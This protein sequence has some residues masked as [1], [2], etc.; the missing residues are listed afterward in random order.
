MR[1]IRF[2]GVGAVSKAW[3]PPGRGCGDHRLARKVAVGNDI[4]K[5]HTLIL[6]TLSRYHC[7][8]YRL[9]G[10]QRPV[11]SI[12]RHGEDGA[13]RCDTAQR[14]RSERYQRYSG[15]GGRS[16]R[17]WRLRGRAK[18]FATAPLMA[19][20][21]RCRQGDLNIMA[22]NLTVGPRVM[23]GI[24]PSRS[25]GFAFGTALPAPKQTMRRQPF[26]AA[27][28]LVSAFS[29]TEPRTRHP[30]KSRASDPTR[31]R[32]AGKDMPCSIDRPRSG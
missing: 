2:G 23:A 8:P 20:R 18:A 14:M 24:D 22:E 13:W 10:R 6:V 3:P 25:L 7:N 9:S 4:V 29:C 19:R 30:D 32:C 28:N 31:P 21:T 17:P 12:L 5:Q 26:V 27:A 11:G 16:G 1:P 15:L